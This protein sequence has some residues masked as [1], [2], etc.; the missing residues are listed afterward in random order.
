M[1]KRL[2]RLRRWRA[3]EGL[4][5]EEVADL[6]GISVAML[7]RAERG[8]REFSPRAKVQLARSLGCR[9]ADLFDVDRVEEPAA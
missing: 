5:L 6:S 9:I 2:T 8:Q 3:S 4:T 7:S 1:S